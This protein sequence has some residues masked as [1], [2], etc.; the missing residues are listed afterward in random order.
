MEMPSGR[1]AGPESEC[2][3]ICM[4]ITTF[5]PG[6]GT[7]RLLPSM[8]VGRKGGYIMILK[9]SQIKTLNALG[10]IL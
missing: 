3:L 8:D 7:S 5:P 10:S 9:V 1:G 4:E 6:C 2:I